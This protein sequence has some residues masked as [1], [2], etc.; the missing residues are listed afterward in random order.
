MIVFQSLLT[1]VAESLSSNQRATAGIPSPGGEGQGEG[2]L[3]TDHRFAFS[4]PLRLRVKKVLF[5]KP[6]QIEKFATPSKS[7]GSPKTPRHFDS[8]NE[9]N[10]LLR[11]LCLRIL[12]VKNPC[13]SVSISGS[14][15]GNKYPKYLSLRKAVQTYARLCKHPLR[16]E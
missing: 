16:G 15:S 14:K 10:F 11:P 4:A 8:K 12:V 6:T 13:L 3:K 7:M 9:P 5:A 2:E 1:G